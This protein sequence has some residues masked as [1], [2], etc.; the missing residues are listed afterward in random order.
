M[1][2]IAIQVH[3]GM[4]YIEETG[5]AQHYR[6]ARIAP[7]YEGTNGIQAMDLVGRK[8]GL[9]GGAAIT[10]FVDD[11]AATAD[12]AAAAG[13]ELAALGTAPRRR[14]R[15]AAR[16]HDVAARQHARPTP[17]TRSPAPRRTSASPG[18]VTGAWVLTRG[19]IAA[20]ALRGRR[21]RRVL[22]RVPRPEAGHRPLLR[23]PGPAAGPRPAA[24]GHGRPGRPLRGVVLTG[25]S[26]LRTPARR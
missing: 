24:G 20:A 18:I 9:R 12:E 4:G 13:G 23:H 7:I 1:T 26:G 3:G 25:G 5:V 2:S 21:P 6:D 22:G 14:R 11:I 8:L 19:A 16:G 17:T 15:R 10:D